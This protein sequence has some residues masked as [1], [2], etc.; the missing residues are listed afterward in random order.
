MAQS[1]IDA[2]QD[3]QITRSFRIAVGSAIFALISALAA[4]WSAWSSAA[5]YKLATGQYRARLEFVD[6]NRDSERF[7]PFMRPKDGSSQLVFRIENADELIRWAPYVQIKNI[8]SSAI[9]AIAIEI[10]YDFGASYGSDVQQIEP[11][12][13]V[14]NPTSKYEATK[15]GKLDPGQTAKVYVAPLL[16]Q[17][18]AKL[19]F[20]QYSEKDQMGM[21]EVKVLG[22]LTGA[23]SYDRMPDDRPVVFTFHWRPV[24]FKPDSTNL[25]ELLE[26][27][28]LVEVDR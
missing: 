17:Q 20:R 8:G 7:K 15:F 18:L 11:A 1:E 21:F 19:K 12:P 23:S 3:R 24:G 16:A 6:Q 10:H 9:D 25:K 5:S 22:R 4:C 14:A 28:P 26:K 27:E 13:I 2:R